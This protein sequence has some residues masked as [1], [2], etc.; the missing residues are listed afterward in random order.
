V[1]LDREGRISAYH[2]GIL[3]K[4]QLDDYLEQAGLKP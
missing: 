3:A 1:I 2:I 4:S